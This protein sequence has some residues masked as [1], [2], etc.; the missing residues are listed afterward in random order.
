PWPELQYIVRHSAARLAVCGDQEQTDKVL[1]AQANEGGL[2]A[3]EH[4]V[5]VD[6][7]GMRHYSQPRLMSFEAL[8]RLGDAFLADNPDADRDLDAMLDDTSPDDVALM[9]YTSG[10]T[11]PPKGAMLTHRN[12]I[13]SAYNYARTVGADT[14]KIEA[15]GYLPLCHAAERCYSMAM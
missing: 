8:L 4:V 13:Y 5:C 7:K 3:L 9:V 12:I 1:E 15:V 11:G 2:P 14:R 6:M 10:T